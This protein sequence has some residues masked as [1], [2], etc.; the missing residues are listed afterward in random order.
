MS[1]WITIAIAALV[2]LMSMVQG[3][4]TLITDVRLLQKGVSETNRLTR[5]LGSRMGSVEKSIIRLENKTFD[6]ET[7]VYKGGESY[8]KEGSI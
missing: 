6:F 2:F 8:A 7:F 1:N 5:D 4:T 3:Y